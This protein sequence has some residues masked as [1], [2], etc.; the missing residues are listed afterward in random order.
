MRE[1]GIEAPELRCPGG[2]GLRVGLVVLGLHFKLHLLAAEGDALGVVF[3]DGQAHA[4]FDVLAQMRLGAGERRGGAELDDFLGLDGR[5]TKTEHGEG[6]KGVFHA[7][8]SSD[9]Y[10]TR[11]SSNF[12][13]GHGRASHLPLLN[14]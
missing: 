1:A 4:V 6:D 10:G 2:G 3:L 5:C 12:G 14:W 7:V 9:W 8:F 13:A 11:L